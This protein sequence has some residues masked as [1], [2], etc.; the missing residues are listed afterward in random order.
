MKRLSYFLVLTLLAAIA[1]CGGSNN[2]PSNVGLFGN[3]NVVMYANGGTAP[4][5]VFAL[6]MSQLGGSNYSG[7]SITYNGSVGIPSNMCINGN[8]LAATATTSG[9][10]FTMTVT[11]RTTNTVITVQGS[12]AT[13]TTTLSGT[14]NNLATSACTAS[15][16]TVT[17]TPQ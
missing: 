15:T 2:T 7:S 13:Q 1:G 17:M 14:Y 8:T 5:Y 16:G 11:D 9:S 4:V 3:W 10:N 12:L 6:A